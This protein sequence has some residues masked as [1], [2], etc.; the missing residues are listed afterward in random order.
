V[1]RRDY[2][3]QDAVGL[4]ALIR[5]GEV[6][7]GEVDDAARRAVE[8]VEPA[9]HATVGELLDSPPAPAGN[10]ALAGVPFGLKDTAP[11]L[12]GQLVQ[13]GSRW[14]GD[15]IRVAEDSY[16]GRR[17]RAGGLRAVARTRAPEFAFNASTEPRAHGPTHNPWDP[18]RS[19][20]GSSGGSAALVAARALPMAHG[21][22]AAGSIRIPA[23]LCGVVGLKPT[24][25]RIP[26]PP[27]AWEAVHGLSHDF[28]LARTLRDVAT[29][30]DVLQGPVPGDKYLI[31]PP[32]RSYCEEMSA[33]P[34][35]LRIRWTADA[36]SGCPV[37]PECR[38]AVE[39]AAT[40][41]DAA[42]H[43]VAEG[44]PT[45][46]S[47][48]LDRA[49]L[50]AWAAA[51]A[52][53]AALLEKA[54]GRPPSPETMEAVTLAM[55]DLGAAT[56]AAALL[57]SYAGCNAIARS[58]GTYF[59]TTDL[60]L[61]PV[62]ARLPWRLGELNQDDAAIG[63]EGWIDKLFDDYCPF[64]AMF[65]ITGQ[66]AISLPLAWTDT[67]L[68]VGVQLVGRFADEATLLRVAGQLEEVFPWAGRLPPLSARD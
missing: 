62:V 57:D 28:I 22:D 27:G 36:W 1:D 55:V 13:L 20:G 21:T 63:A 64:T 32:V 5:K 50:T 56:S 42:G 3:D 47:E 46:N 26:I 65:N 38:S 66:P 68:P 29:A 59:E 7:A 39:A 60:L 45:I 33:A 43:D 2:A 41:L 44:T 58:V 31:P 17:F 30:L 24:R 67:G 34:G 11:H 9:L 6:T 49:L 12:E 14:T 40:A 18:S 10:G 37:D 35:P 16:L 25:A 48:V 54:L 4:A 53:R 51:L 8:A 19:V 15:G 23:S 52:Q 61:L